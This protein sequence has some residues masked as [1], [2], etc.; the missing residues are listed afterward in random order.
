MS[1]RALTVGAG[2]IAIVSACG[3]SAGA[4]TT[5]GPT[6]GSVATP[7]AAPTGAVSAAPS[8]GSTGR[9][10]LT[11][12]GF[13]ITL[14]DGWSRIPV[15]Q[16]SLEAF[17]K[18]LPADSDLGKIMLSQA[19]QMAASGIKLW[20]MDVSPDAVV[21]GFTPNLNVITQPVTG[22]SLD[23]LSS[24]AKAQ[25]DAVSAISGTT[26][27]PVKIPAGD[28]VKA[29]YALHQVLASGAA[30]DVAGI[31]YYVIGPGRLYILSF[32]CPANDGGGCA[33]DVDSMIQSMELTS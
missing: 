24:M 16:A 32:S 27:E 2:L 6:A 33:A 14:P 23:V 25:L 5:P 30:L 22:L 26:M 10:A 31:Q 4:T 19:G 13:A 28:A 1:I 17:T 15:D 3:G 8:L 7:S 18:A 21:S 20:A 11:D 12:E 9:I 29:T